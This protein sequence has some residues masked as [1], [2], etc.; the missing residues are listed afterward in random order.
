MKI[1]ISILF[2]LSFSLTAQAASKDEIKSVLKFMETQGLF[3]KEDLEQAQKD[4]DTMSASDWSELNNVA[5]KI[6][7][8]SPGVKKFKESIQKGKMPM[9]TK[10]RLQ[11]LKEEMR[12]YQNA[13]EVIQSASPDLKK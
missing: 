3:K 8:E 2:V 6:T 5:T 7:K 13:S 4:M 10:G 12:G 11:E 1:F 9:P